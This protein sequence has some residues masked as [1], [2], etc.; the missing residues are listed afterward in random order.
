MTNP[1]LQK[2]KLPGRIFQLPS[3]GIFYKQGVL[4][5]HVRDGEVEVQPMSALAEMKL[6]SPDML[7]SGRALR[8]I[9][10]ECIP[11]ILKPDE[12]VSKD[13]DAIF[14]FLRIVTYGP[15]MEF[16]SVHNCPNRQ[17]HE[18][19][20]S[21]ENI[22]LKPNNKILEHADVLYT[23]KLSNEQTIKLRP[24]RF[25]DAVEM[26]HL[27]QEAEK[28]LESDGQVDQAIIENT[29]VSDLLT[30]IDA[31]DGVVD[32]AMIEE[33]VRSLPRKMF[34][35]IINKSRLASDWGFDL[36]VEVTCADCGTAYLHD[37]E[38]DP[39]NFFSE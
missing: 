16:R 12:L 23:F 28:Q 22:T 5:E 30:I 7:F 9:C 19:K 31:V 4:A 35:E 24:V 37:L 17:I 2:T 29:M 34:V 26:L 25:Q 1:L 18:Y 33:W 21:L 32:R 3:K 39:I 11:D 36:K 27:Q 15:I 14:C 20:S 10:L 38:L 8:E 13:V 6:R